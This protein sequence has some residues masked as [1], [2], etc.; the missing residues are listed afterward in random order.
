MT[1]PERSTTG[2]ELLDVTE[3]ERLALKPGDI[4]VLKCPRNVTDAE[5]NEISAQFRAQLPDTQVL[6]L[7]GGMDIAVLRAEP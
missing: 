7:E 1:G 3:V 2:A 6:V 4:L 5:F